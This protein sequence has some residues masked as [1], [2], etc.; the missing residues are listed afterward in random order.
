MPQ[1]GSYDK[2]IT[3]QVANM[4][5]SYKLKESL[6]KL[7]QK[8]QSIENLKLEYNRLHINSIL[9]RLQTR[10]AILF[11]RLVEAIKKHDPSST[12]LAAEILKIRN[13]VRKLQT[14]QEVIEHIKYI[15]SVT[16]HKKFRGELNES[17]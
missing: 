9:F 16:K 2:I 12:I 3:L 7:P 8:V 11:T 17:L 14:F 5:R 15:S 6:D 13:L 1:I 10:D 4:Q